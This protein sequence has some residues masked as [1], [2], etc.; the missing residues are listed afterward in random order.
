MEIK[1]GADPEFF[2]RRRRHFISGHM[3]PIGTK[4]KPMKTEH[5]F[6]QV[7]GIAVEANVTPA[8]TCK[9]FVANV[10]GVKRDLGTIVAAEQ[11][12]IV[13]R[14]S[15]FFGKKKLVNLPATASHLGCTPDFDA[16]DLKMNNP[17]NSN[18][19]IRTGAGHV[20]IG[21]TTNQDVNSRSWVQFCAGVTQQLDFYLG[22]PS[23]LWDTDNR[24]RTLY[25][26]AGAF[27]PKSYGLEYRVLSN[28]WTD[29]DYHIAWI[30]NQTKK[31]MVDFFEGRRL[32]QAWGVL[33]RGYI[34]DSN[35]KW[36]T[37]YPS[38]AHTVMARHAD[39]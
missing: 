23:L 26:R 5:G 3:F 30:F 16:Y 17:P 19:P 11:C 7:D 39:N 29:T 35:P 38:I 33:A 4:D 22:L 12:Q 36:V 14:P 34:N 9:E 6:V 37:P 31:A 20:H 32:P 28:K 18:S 21:W 25:G 27:R 10:Q 15:I 24:R 2:V 1:I 8:T 13:A